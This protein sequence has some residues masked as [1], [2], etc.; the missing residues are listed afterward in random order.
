MRILR[1]GNYLRDVENEKRV[2]DVITSVKGEKLVSLDNLQRL[3]QWTE[4]H[5]FSPAIS[6]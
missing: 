2:L 1:E 4:Q 3:E 6:V 5:R